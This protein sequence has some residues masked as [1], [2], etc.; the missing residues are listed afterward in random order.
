MIRAVLA[1]KGDVLI[2][3]LARNGREVARDGRL[4]CRLEDRRDPAV[5]RVE[6]FTGEISAVTVE[7]SGPVRA[8]VKL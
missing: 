5:K 8:V 3:S 4:V 6:A 1:R 2:R 7:Q